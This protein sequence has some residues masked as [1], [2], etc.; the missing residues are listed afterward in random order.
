MKM[1]YDRK[2]SLFSEKIKAHLK[3]AKVKQTLLSRKLQI[4]PSAV[5]QMLKCNIVMSLKQLQTICEYINLSEKDTVELQ[6]LLSSIRA[7][8]VDV[9]T[10]FNRFVR[11]CRRRKGWHILKLSQECGI[12][13]I[14]LR[15]F[16]EDL[17]VSFTIE[18]AHKL[19]QVYSDDDVLP[20]DF[21]KKLP[22]GTDDASN[23]NYPVREEEHCVLDVAEKATPYIA[24][25]R[26]KIYSLDKFKEYVSS[27]DL[28]GFADSEYLKEVES[29]IERDVIGI[30]ADAAAVNMNIAGTVCLFVTDKKT[31]SGACRLF[32]CKDNEK[33]YRLLQKIEDDDRFFVT[34]PNGKLSVF[35]GR[36]LWSLAIVELKFIP[37]TLV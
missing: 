31:F 30:E 13:P 6:T 36:V 26:V 22:I 27:L 8:S 37:K 18:D 1:T 14:R 9:I 23:I 2:V 10:P 7:G 21:I 25:R 3:E 29:D 12:S 24:R 33:K 15:S 19:A 20:E 4:T 32:L 5:S 35:D 28:F 16:E 17:N 34:M 11:D